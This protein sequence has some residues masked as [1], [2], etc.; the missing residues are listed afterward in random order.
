M[1]KTICLLT[2]LVIITTTTVIAQKTETWYD[3]N[4][5]PCEPPMARFYGT[6][7]KTDSGW[8]RK[9]YFLHSGKATLQMQA[10]YED[11][12]CK[13]QH[14]QTYYYYANGN[15]QSA[16]RRVHGKREGICVS[17][18][19]NGMMSDSAFW[20]ENVPQGIQFRWHRNGYVSDSINYINNNTRTEVSWWDNGGLAAA[21]Y[22]QNDNMHGKWKFYHRN[23][24]LAGEEVYDNGKVISKTYF[25]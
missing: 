18:H 15:L 14:G 23:G 17:Y 11:A 2:M 20:H 22:L 8:F 1:Q 24:Q 21:G 19:S 13:V 6:V 12:D 25:N 3:Y 5:K 10:L 16:G 7:E 4:W 9:D